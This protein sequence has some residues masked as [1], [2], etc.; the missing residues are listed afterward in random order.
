MKIQFRA[1]CPITSS[2]DILG[3]KWMLVIIKQMLIEHKKTFKDFIESE[4]AIATNILS[5]RLKLLEEYDLVYK[6]K[7]PDNKKAN[8]Y[9]L[10]Q[11][12]IDLAP[13]IVE[14]SIWSESN[15]SGDNPKLIKHPETE[16]VIQYKVQAIQK[17][18]EAYKNIVLLGH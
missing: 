1:T 3:D 6:T 8:I 2:L 4:E 12:G 11:K 18:K 10:T 17:I 7:L 5:S 14:L 15:L 9:L 13:V 16:T